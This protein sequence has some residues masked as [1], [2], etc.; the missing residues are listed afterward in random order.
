MN[1]IFLGAPG[2]GKGTMATRLASEMH[3]PHVSTGDIFRE[4]I[5]NKTALG[6]QAQN[7]LNQGGLVPDE[8]TTALIK[9][10]LEAQDVQA[11]YILDGFP[12]TIPQAISLEKITHIEGVIYFSLSEEKVLE[13]LSGR[14]VHP[15][16]GRTYHIKYNPPATPDKDDITGEPLVI[17]PDDKEETIRNRLQSYTTQT[18]PLIDFYREKGQLLTIDASPEP[19]QVFNELSTTLKSR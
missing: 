6:L 15:A 14:R 18:A 17:R 5:R 3:I 10:R 13:R 1:L 16:S 2:A 4:H 11:G 19:D 8:I 9:Q 12:R 7:I